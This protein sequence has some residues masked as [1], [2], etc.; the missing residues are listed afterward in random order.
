MLSQWASEGSGATSWVRDAYDAAQARRGRGRVAEVALGQPLGQPPQA[1][2]DAL[3]RA[4]A[5]R[6][7]GRFAYMPNLGY[8]ELRERAALECG[9]PGLGAD[10]VAI[11]AGASGALTVALRAFADPGT[12]ALA[13][14]PVFPEYALYCRAAGV[15]LVSVP[16]RPDFTL[17]LDALEQALT[18]R[19]RVLFLNTPNNPTGRVLSDPELTRLAEL[20]ERHWGRTGRRVVVLADEVYRKVVYT[21]RPAPTAL[22]HYPATAVA[23]SF[24]KDLGLAGERIGYL[25]LH[26]ELARGSAMAGVKFAQRAGGFVNASATMQRMLLLLDS[27]EVDLSEHLRRRDH[28]VKRLRAAGL[29]VEPPDAGLYLFFRVPAPDPEAFTAALGDRNVFVAPGRGFGAPDHV[30]ICFTSPIE[31]VERAIDV[32]GELAMAGASTI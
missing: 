19:T 7:P 4:V 27:W 31:A 12:E 5:E 32:I 8:P 25:A 3:A 28:A 22:F 10:C 21:G 26:P 15:R 11:T 9:L 29:A 1:V 23:R 24:S 30:R 17:D 20:L 14:S 18:E 16:S 6:W 2:L 13:I